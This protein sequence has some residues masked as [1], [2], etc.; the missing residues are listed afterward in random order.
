MLG[1]DAGK[2]ELPRLRKWFCPAGPQC[3]IDKVMRLANVES[4][5]M[6]N[7]VFDDNERGRWLK[8][9]K[10]LRGDPRFTAVLRIDPILRD[11]PKASAAAD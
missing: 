2:K 10:K 5:T 7:P 4:I 3:T 11:W 8:D 9:A 6:T 1:L